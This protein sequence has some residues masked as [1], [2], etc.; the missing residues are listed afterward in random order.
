MTNLGWSLDEET[1]RDALGGIPV[2]LLND[3]EA[4]AHGV[5]GLP[6]GDLRILT[7]GA[8]APGAPARRGNLAVVAAGTGLGE[9]M[10][11]WHDDVPVVIAS[12]GGHA[13]FAP[14]DETETA[15]AAWLSR[16]DP[17]VSCEDVISG[18]AILRIHQFLRETGRADEP[19]AL[20][21]RLNAAPE[22]ST[23][24][25]RAGID[26]EFPICVRAL[27]IFA[28]AYGAEAGNLALKGFALGGVYV[29]GGIAPE[30]LEGRFAARFMDA[31]VA[32]GRY[33]DF[34]R[35][36]PV[37]VVVCGRASLVGATAVGRRLAA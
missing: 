23:V 30:L 9:A 13:D 24:L 5:L 31:F 26:A 32:K 14:R 3:L 2:R 4:A 33:A 10:L 37:R 22:P 29:A 1:L 6:S 27:E 20:R 8:P 7:P 35:R 25:T 36:I 34:M 21:A 28:G 19:A 18:P 12:E 16:H 17:H 15:L 11:T